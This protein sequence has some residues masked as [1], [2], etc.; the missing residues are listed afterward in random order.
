M[1]REIHQLSF[2]R[3]EKRALDGGGRQ[4]LDDQGI[5]TRSKVVQDIVFLSHKIIRQRQ[6]QVEHTKDEDDAESQTGHQ[7]V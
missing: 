6:E 4:P 1:P 3:L 5:R 2:S 7:S